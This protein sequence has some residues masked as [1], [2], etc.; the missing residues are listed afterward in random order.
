MMAGLRSLFRVFGPLYMGMQVFLIALTGC[1][2]VIRIVH[3][4]L[5]AKMIPVLIFFWLSGELPPPGVRLA[6]R[7]GRYLT[8]LYPWVVSNRE[9][10]SCVQGRTNNNPMLSFQANASLFYIRVK[11]GATTVCVY[12]YKAFVSYWCSTDATGARNVVGKAL[13]ESKYPPDS[14]VCRSLPVQVSVLHN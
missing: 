13:S 4:K 14:V 1:L 2:P 6:K 12:R 8:K 10:N 9:R 5:I 11:N 3:G 7:R